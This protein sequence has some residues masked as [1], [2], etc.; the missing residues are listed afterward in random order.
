MLTQE[1]KRQLL[2]AIAARNGGVLRVEDIVADAEAITSE[3]HGEFN[4][5]DVTAAYAHRLEQAR[6]LVRSVRVEVK[7]ET[8][9]LSVVHYVRDPR[10]SSNE[11]GYV[12][13][14]Q[15][16]TESELARDA[17][18]AEFGRALAVLKRAR[19]LSVA[20]GMDARVDDIVQRLEELANTVPAL[21]AVI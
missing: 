9:S 15:L 5:D 21:R 10:P 16:R 19:D 1:K 18:I 12:S 14:P 7:T 2:D 13:L 4:W 20:L 8:R 3:L 6:A 17:L 11:S